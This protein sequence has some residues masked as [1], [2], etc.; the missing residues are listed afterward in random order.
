MAPLIQQSAAP[1]V[2]RHGADTAAGQQYLDPV[3]ALAFPHAQYPPA[4]RPAR[5]LCGGILSYVS[6]PLRQVAH[7]LGRDALLPRVPAC[8]ARWLKSGR[9]HE[10]DK[11]GT[12]LL[13]HFRAYS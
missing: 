12:A 9:R 10:R 3:A 6:T 13:S 5:L 7:R 8:V 4:G 1:A 2:Y 11:Q